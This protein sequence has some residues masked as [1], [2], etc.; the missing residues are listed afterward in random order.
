MIIVDIRGSIWP[1]KINYKQMKLSSL[2][3][4][5]VYTLFLAASFLSCTIEEGSNRLLVKAS[6]TPGEI[7]LVMDS[8]QWNGELGEAMRNTLQSYVPGISRPEKLFTVRYIEPTLFNSVLNK[9]QNLIFVA[10]MD[11][12]TQG[13]QTVRNFLSKNYIP[14][15]PD[16]FILSQKDIFASGQNALY[17][18]SST[19]EELTERINNNKSIIRNF[20]NQKENDRLLRAL[21]TAKE[22]K[23]VSS[24]MTKTHGFSVRVPTG[25][26]IE[27]DDPAFF[28]LRNVGQI[29][30]NIFFSYRDYTSEEIFNNSNLIGLR[31]SITFNNVFEDPEDSD[32]YV[33]VDTMNLETEYV[34]TK[35]N[36]QYAK[37]IRGIWKANNL[38]IGGSFISY[39]FVDS[40]TN[41]LY[42]IDG[43]VI[44]PGKKKREAMRELDVI[45]KTFRT[46]KE[47]KNDNPNI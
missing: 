20:F 18:F 43:F 9:A 16:D 19:T 15:H 30:K 6:G 14:D 1:L 41:R 8:L 46:P 37:R 4:K 10:T 32:S 34:T 27:A 44:A 24:Y 7:I 33:K 45:L 31:D 36:G 28:W 40:T 21:F 11:S 13:G 26:R 35:I 2:L 39:V 3:P 12:K 38:T 5:Y 23:A 29:D 42:Y 47:L 22:E 17:L 25:Y